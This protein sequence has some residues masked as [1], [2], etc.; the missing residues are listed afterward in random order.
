M[1]KDVFLPSIV[2]ECQHYEACIYHLD[3]PGALKHLDALLE[4]EELAAIQWVY[5]AGHGRAS[6][7]LHVYRRCQ[8]AGKALQLSGIEPDEIDLFMEHLRPEGLWI[9]IQSVEDRAH[10]EALLKR[11]AEWR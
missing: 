7:W 5:G 4:I 8:Q 11:V 3:G 10:G 6:D 2:A 9:G 1:F